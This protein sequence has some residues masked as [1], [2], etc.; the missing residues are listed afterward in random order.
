MTRTLLL[1][2]ALLTGCKDLRR[3]WQPTGN[4]VI[5]RENARGGSKDWNGGF[6]VPSQH[7]AEIYLD[8]VSAEAGDIVAVSISASTRTTGELK[9]FRFGWYGGAGARLVAESGQIPLTPQSPCLHSPV[10][11]LVRCRWLS[12]P[13]VIPAD[14][15][16]GLYAIRV[17]TSDGFASFAPLVVVDHRRA[18]LLFQASVLTY[19]AYNDWGG[20]SLYTDH[21]GIP[22]GHAIEVSFDRP[23][24]SANGLDARFLLLELP[25]ARFLE[26]FGYD[27][28]YT[29]NLDVVHDGRN[30]IN[31]GAFLSVGHDEYWPGKERTLLDDA[32]HEGVSA[33]FFGAN[34][35]YWRVRL[36]EPGARSFERVVTCYKSDPSIDPRA[37]TPEGTGQF[38][39]GFV[40]NPEEHLIGTMYG[41]LLPS[42]F[43]LVVTAPRHFLYAGTGLEEGDVLGPIVGIEYDRTHLDS[44]NAMAEV[45]ARSPVADVHG[46]FDVAE[47]T[48]Y[49]NDAGA[50]VFGAATMSWSSG[51]DG[52]FESPR[53]QRIT[54]NVLHAA[55]GVAVPDGL[56]QLSLPAPDQVSA[57]ASMVRSIRLPGVVGAAGVVGLPDGS[58]VVSD[59]VLNRLFIVADPS[60]MPF[61]GNGSAETPADVEGAASAHFAGPTGLVAD[62]TGNVFV[63]DTGHH[64]IR[65]IAARSPAVVSIAAGQCGVQGFQ[66]GPLRNSQFSW[67]TALSWLPN[68]QLVVADSG[69]GRVRAIDFASAQTSTFVGTGE[70]SERDG[71][72]CQAGS[73]CASFARPIA[74]ATGPD[75]S[76]YVS[77]SAGSLRRI[78]PDPTRRVTSIVVGGVGYADGTG[79]SARMLTALALA[80]NGVGLAITDSGNHRIRRVVP[81]LDATSTLVGTVAG[82]GRS[83]V[84]DGPGATATFGMPL[85]VW[86]GPQGNLYVADAAAQAIR[87][88]EQ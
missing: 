55:T 39:S 74:L 47:T 59:S 9:L 40:G 4:I 60:V 11:G 79:V 73:G 7:E 77:S 54:A 49:R 36:S 17:D 70:H 35:S 38:R 50:L 86:Q 85:G 23:Y 62:E 63:A 56:Q 22:G 46:K 30:R 37:G 18:D 75:G 34:A 52:E 14:A 42:P 64:C 16:S 76:L 80:W 83:G 25:M 68:G 32:V 28:T 78:S 15:T 67:P 66:D 27:V 21:D 26:R 69:N 29:T 87:V 20:E 71:I 1:L 84:S 5:T 19:Q 82:S 24:S 12:V 61:A 43:A 65:K 31:Y 6:R 88:V 44:R 13:F 33:L 8:R 45:V 81:G 41:A 57:Y 3:A 2:L 53:L 72:G 51:L 10:T 58:I 48:V